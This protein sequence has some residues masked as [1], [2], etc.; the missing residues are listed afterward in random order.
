MYDV[1]R[2]GRK[3]DDARGID[4]ELVTILDQMVSSGEPITVRAVV[5]RMTTLRHASSITRDAWRMDRIRTAEQEAVRTA[6]GGLAIVDEGDQEQTSGKAV[7]PDIRHLL[8]FACIARAGNF[9]AAARELQ[10]GQ[11]TLSRRI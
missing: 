5:R 10:V 11:P 8:S 1:A 3:T 2:P 7:A 4:D 9:G 6:V